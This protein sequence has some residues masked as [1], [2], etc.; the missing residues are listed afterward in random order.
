MELLTEQLDTPVAILMNNEQIVDGNKA[1]LELFKLKSK[2]DLKQKSLY[3]FSADFQVEG[4]PSLIEFKKI[5]SRFANQSKVKFSWILK[6]PDGNPCQTLCTLS[7]LED[8]KTLLEIHEVNNLQHELHKTKEMGHRFQTM[9]DLAPVGILLRNSQG[10][11]IQANQKMQTIIGYSEAELCTLSYQ[12]LLTEKARNEYQSYQVTL[13]LM[14]RLDNHESELLHQDGHV[15]PVTKAE[16]MAKNMNGTKKTWSFFTDLSEI[17]KN[18][19]ELEIQ[20]SKSA[21]SA[22]LAS[23]GEMAGGIAHEI[24]NPLTII[25]GK[26]RMIARALDKESIDIPQVKEHCNKIESTVT[27]IS[28]II[29]GLKNFSRD[30]ESELPKIFNLRQ[31][32]DETYA[33]CAEKFKN[34]GINFEMNVPPEYTLKCREV[35]LSQVILNLLSNAHDAI[36]KEKNE[37]SEEKTSPWIKVVAEEKNQNLQIRIIDSG[38][39]IPLAVQ[40]KIFL[41]FFT[42]KIMGKGTGLGLSISRSIIEKNKGNLYIDNE[43]SNTCFVIEFNK[44]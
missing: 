31:L 10:Q 20:Q 14:E 1:L 35:Q 27:R 9:F 23:I 39:G 30:T 44:A 11:I 36:Y 38:H 3:D 21:A 6:G 41:P 17:K 18:A 7:K 19:E 29:I 2:E 16:M 15:V 25:S 34:H 43:C 32:M 4:E 37:E 24:N 5:M 28:K 22:R 26:A 8:K 42:T 12:K 40:E 33:L 13:E